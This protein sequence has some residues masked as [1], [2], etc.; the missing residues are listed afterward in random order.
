[1]GPGHNRVLYIHTAGPISVAGT[2][3]VAPVGVQLEPS[4]AVPLE[5]GADV[6][7]M[8]LLSGRPIGEEVAQH[9]PFVMNTRLELREAFDEYRRTGFGGWSWPS[10]APVHPPE[11]GRFAVHGDGRTENP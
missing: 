11:R 4:S 3:M 10:D 6:S 9:G 5:N 2:E 7:E 8:L 1:M